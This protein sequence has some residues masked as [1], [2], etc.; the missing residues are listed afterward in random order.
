MIVTD[1][2]I[3]LDL[4]ASQRVADLLI[5]LRLLLAEHPE[6]EYPRVKKGI[7]VKPSIFRGGIRKGI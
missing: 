5:V 2:S 4:G 1:L 3:F 7:I 6:G